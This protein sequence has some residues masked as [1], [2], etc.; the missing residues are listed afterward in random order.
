MFRPIPAI[1]RFT[2]EIVL[3]FIR[4]MRLCNDGEISSSEVL[5]IT[6]IKRRG[7][8]GGVF[9]NVGIVLRWGVML[10]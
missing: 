4:F 7:C 2:P 3:I 9:S 1:I 8:G 5:I 10:A 6:T